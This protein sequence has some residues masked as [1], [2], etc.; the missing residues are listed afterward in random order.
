MNTVLQLPASLSDTLT[1]Y[2][3]TEIQMKKIKIWTK[4][5][6]PLKT[7][8]IGMMLGTSYR[9]HRRNEYVW[10]QVILAVCQELSLSTVKR[11]KLSWF[12]HV[13]CHP[14]TTDN[15]WSVHSLMLSFNDLRR[16]SLRWL[17][18]KPALRI[19]DDRNP[20]ASITAEASVIEHN[21]ARGSW[22]LVS[23]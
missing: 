23:C 15:D 4:E 7:K 1:Y 22:E 6:K 12:G 5:S 11:H 21:D 18:I 8:A 16:S 13:C 19:A 14:D 2:W 20:W 10:Q 17:P 3:N 9:E